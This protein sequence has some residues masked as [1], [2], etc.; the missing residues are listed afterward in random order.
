MKPNE[1]KARS[2][3][4]KLV[5]VKG[6]LNT[7]GTAEFGKCFT[8]GRV[9]PFEVLQCG[10]F[11]SGRT[12]ALFFEPTNAHIQCP[13]CNCTKGGNLEIYHE[14]MIRKYGE[15]E[16]E[17]LESMRHKIIKMYESDYRE[18]VSKFQSEFE[19]IEY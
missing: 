19:S 8:C 1:K 16:V 14:K 3:Y 12:S 18:L 11:V 17:R 7:T 10:H 6:C 4:S 9:F 13:E 2:L 15:K 5:R